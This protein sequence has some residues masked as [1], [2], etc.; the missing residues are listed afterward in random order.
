[1]F[2][3]RSATEEYLFGTTRDSGSTNPGKEIYVW[4]APFTAGGEDLDNTINAAVFKH[5]DSLPPKMFVTA[6]RPS[7]DG[8]KVHMLLTYQNM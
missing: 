8:T 3:E 5:L 6:L 7:M 4:K 2:F 1:M